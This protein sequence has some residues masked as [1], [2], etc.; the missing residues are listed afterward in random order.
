MSVVAI[1]GFE[2]CGPTTTTLKTYIGR[3]Y[4]NS[5]TSA[6]L[7]AGPETDKAISL[8]NGNYFIMPVSDLMK[9]YV[10]FAFL[11]KTLPVAEDRILEF[12]DGGV[13]QDSLEIT[14][15]GE[16]R[17]RIGSSGAVFET[18]SG[19]GLV[20]DTWYYIEV[21]IR[22]KNAPDGEYEVRVDEVTVMDDTGIDTQAT[23]G[24]HCDAVLPRKV[25]VGRAAYYDDIYI[26]DD[27]GGQNDELIGNHT[28][29]VI[30]PNGDTVDE[31]FTALNG[32][33]NYAE[34]DETSVDDD[35]TYNQSATATHKDLFDYTNLSVTDN[36]KAVQVNTECRET[37]AN[38]FTLVST[39]DSNGTEVQDGAVAMD[40]TYAN[41]AYI[42]EEDPDTIVLWTLA[43][44]NAATFGYE[45][46]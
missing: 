30:Y 11:V 21:Y 23:A 44:L 3:R 4:T 36:I 28:V 2:A 7:V 41:I 27:G 12:Q 17:L 24:D 39:C 34:V 6:T 16:L 15:T 19:L 37:D 5:L 8:A 13:A 22:F 14:S 20:I 38:P 45:I 25:G 18:T 42:V 9:I 1:E 40:Q 29:H 35:T 43:G 46:G 10:G 33:D 31:D 26:C 32:G